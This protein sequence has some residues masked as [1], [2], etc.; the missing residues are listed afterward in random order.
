MPWTKQKL[1]ACRSEG[2]KKTGQVRSQETNLGTK[3]STRSLLY[4]PR[5]KGQS[6]GSK[7]SCF[8]EGQANGYLAVFSLMMMMCKA[9]WRN[10]CSVSFFLAP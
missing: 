6:W 9:S 7:R 1:K 3:F 2:S 4:Q 10:L 5:E 8:V